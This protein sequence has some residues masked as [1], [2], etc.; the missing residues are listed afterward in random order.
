[1]VIEGTPEPQI[2]RVSRRQYCALYKFT[3]L[4]TYKGKGLVLI[5]HTWVKV[6]TR[7]TL[8]SRKWQL[9]SMG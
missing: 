4:L 6:V 8:Q 1:M 7:S 9:I 3:Y 2:R 5:Q